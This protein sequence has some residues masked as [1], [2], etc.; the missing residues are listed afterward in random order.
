MGL[1]EIMC[2]TSENCKALWNFKK[3][4]RK[5]KTQKEKKKS[6]QPATMTWAYLAVHTTLQ[7]TVSSSEHHL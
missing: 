4:K 6:K 2:E 5:E 3:K 1:Y 7:Y